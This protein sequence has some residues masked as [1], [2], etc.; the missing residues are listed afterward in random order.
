[1]AENSEKPKKKKSGKITT[2]FFI[3]SLA[4][5]AVIAITEFSGNKDRHLEST[6]F[7]VWFLFGAIGCFLVA[8]FCETVKYA[9]L[10]KGKGIKNRWKLGFTD[11]VIGKYYDNITP[12]GAGGQGFQMYHLKKNGCDFGTAGGLPII[13]FMGLQFAFVFVGVLTMIFG[14]GLI[15]KE[16]VV[17]KVT[18]IAGLIFYAFIPMCI[19]FFI[20]APKPLEAIVRWAT[21]LLARIHIVKDPDTAVKNAIGSLQA[22]TAVLRSFSRQGSQIVFVFV[23]SLIYQLALMCMPWFV[24]RFFGADIAFLPCFC[25]VVYVYAAITLVFTPGN[26]GAAEASFYMVF[27]TLKGGAI[28]WGMLVWR[29]LCFYSWILLGAIVQSCERI[30]DRKAEAREAA[31]GKAAECEQTAVNAQIA[32]G[33]GTDSADEMKQAGIAEYK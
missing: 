3:F 14:N 1:M 12:A 32:G 17:L 4:I 26:S 15:D 33:I 22:Y 23:V 13:G 11:A 29:G 24:L 18:A 16:M 5:V 20:I 2:F 31:G 27:S 21:R 28:F 6:D 8:L 19:V 25:K 7:N 9:H 30:R 10:L